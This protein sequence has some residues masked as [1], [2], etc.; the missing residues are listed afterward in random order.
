M[1]FKV[2][3]LLFAGFREQLGRES[4][5]WEIDSQTKLSTLISQLRLEGPVLCAVNQV[6]V[7]PD[8]TLREG[9]EVALMP[10]MSGG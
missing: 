10:P 8:R 7:N 4:L 1:Y 5:E 9:D 3:I 6:Q 2:T